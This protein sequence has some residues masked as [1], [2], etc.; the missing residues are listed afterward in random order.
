MDNVSSNLREG[1]QVIATG[2]AHLGAV[3]VP[4]IVLIVGL[5]WWLGFSAGQGW[6]QPASIVLTALGLWKTVTAIIRRQTTRLTIT[7]QRFFGES[8]FMPH[9]TM[10][11]ALTDI[12]SVDAKGDI[13][14][15]VL[16]YG[17][18]LVNATGKGNLRVQYP[19]IADAPQLAATFRAQMAKPTVRPTAPRSQT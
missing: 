18:L 6:Q 8:G 9:K 15:S 7:D 10:T 14:G 1:E 13:F 11:L 16:G 2:K 4:V 5:V 19:Q 17:T 12:D 3:I